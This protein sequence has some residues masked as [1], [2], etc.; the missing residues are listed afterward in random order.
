MTHRQ[1]LKAGYMLQEYCIRRV[2][3]Q[4]G[5]GIVY[6]AFDTTLEQDV[7]IK[8]YLPSDI[9][10]RE[11]GN[12]VLSKSTDDEINFQWGLQR[13]ISEAKALAA[14]RKS[15]NIV[16]VLRYFTMHNTG[17]IV[18]EYIDALSLQDI[19][20]SRGY[21]TQIELKDMLK[22]LLT[23]L[24]V[25]HTQGILHRDIK[26]ENILLNKNGQPI[27]IDFGS[28]KQDFGAKTRTAVGTVSHG[29]SAIEQYSQTNIQ[30]AWTD[31]YSL[32]AVLYE[33]VTGIP[34]QDAITRVYDDKLEP[35]AQ[36]AKEKYPV[37]FFQ[38]IDWGLKLY[39]QDRPQAVS[40]WSNLLLKDELEI[41][42][43]TKKEVASTP[44]KQAQTSKY[45]HLVPSGKKLA[46]LLISIALGFTLINSFLLQRIYQEKNLN[47]QTASNL[48]PAIE[49]HNK[50]EAIIASN[51]NN[52]L[53]PNDEVP[54]KALLPQESNTND[55]PILITEE[56]KTHTVE[57]AKQVINSPS[58]TET[59][60]PPQTPISEVNPT[61]TDSVNDSS[62]GTTT[63]EI[64]NNTITEAASSVDAEKNSPDIVADTS[65]ST[66]PVLAS[67]PFS[68]LGE[69]TQK[70]ESLTTDIKKEERRLEKLDEW[71]KTATEKIKLLKDEDAIKSYDSQ[72]LKAK[73]ARSEAEE[74]L[75]TTKQTYKELM[76]KYCDQESQLDNYH[77]L[78][79]STLRQHL[80][81]SC[82][83]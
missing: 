59:T 15:P 32:A 8:E 24:N 47:Q 43:S 33:C 19:L 48:T 10:I 66:A 55:S 44:I 76:S 41:D 12:T 69:D 34:P 56:T 14:L 52:L 22:K 83:E 25:I 81:T 57:P 20:N 9:A 82:K 35:V 42:K 54:E 16:S 21:L 63:T 6:L 28:A 77:S 64:A 46:I 53:I 36:I 13:F 1:A 75:K 39:G 80:K 7:V 71:E 5:F 27:L 70:M 67:S 61:T 79:I 72:L 51:N 68:S 18:M 78:E 23:A 40:E 62:L 2:L 65:S 37:N 17:Y 38:A 3:G 60:T 29:Y 31:I 26:P 50:N 11:K 58:T 74:K 45:S 49:S 4:G 73:K 30:G